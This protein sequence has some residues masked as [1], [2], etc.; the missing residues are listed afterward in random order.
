MSLLLEEPQTAVEI[1]QK[2]EIFESAVRQHL[3]MLENAGL[4]TATFEQRGLGRPKKIFALSPSG[5]ELFTRK[6]DVLLDLVI[7][8]ISETYGPPALRSILLSTARELS[9]TLGVVSDDLPYRER[10]RKVTEALDDLGFAAKLEEKD[11]KTSIVS[12]NC[13]L[14]RTAEA[15]HDLLCH[16]FHSELIRAALKRGRV[17]LHECMVDG[18]PFCTHIVI[19]SDRD[20]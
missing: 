13:I 20:D 16:K 19:K 18:A 10:L 6:Y 7:R 5:A 9:I 17:E 11:G 1:A 8:K 3:Q 12:K 2:L 15:N 14:L 4:V